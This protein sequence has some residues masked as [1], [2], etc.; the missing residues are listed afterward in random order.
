MEQIMKLFGEIALDMQPPA[1]PEGTR[2]MI[3][4]ATEAEAN[5]GIETPTGKVVVAGR[6]WNVVRLD[7]EFRPLTN[8]D[9]Y[10]DVHTARLERI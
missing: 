9:G 3:K 10:I 5:E 4:P 8:P 1:F 2:V 7:E 6:E